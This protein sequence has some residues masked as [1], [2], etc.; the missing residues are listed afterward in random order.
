MACSLCLVFF[1]CRTGLPV[2]TQAEETR[3]WQRKDGK[4]QNVH[5]HRSGSSSAPNK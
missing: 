3:V 1:T 2:T 5:L 4:W